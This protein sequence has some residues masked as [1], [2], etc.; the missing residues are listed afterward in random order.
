M[1]TRTITWEEVR[2]RTNFGKHVWLPEETRPGEDLTDILAL[3]EWAEPDEQGQVALGLDQYDYSTTVYDLRR[4]GYRRWPECDEHKLFM[5][6]GPPNQHKGTYFCC[7]CGRDFDLVARKIS[8]P[9]QDAGPG[10]EVE[11]MVVT[12]VAPA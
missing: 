9:D 6:M 8:V 10:A 5:N 2:R 4:D 7:Y 1:A 12:V 3:F 11:L